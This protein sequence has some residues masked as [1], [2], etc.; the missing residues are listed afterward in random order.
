MRSALYG[1][2]RTVTAAR[3][4]TPGYEASDA[5]PWIGVTGLATMA[6]LVILALG[7]AAV[8]LHVFG[9]QRPLVASVDLPPAGPRLTVWSAPAAPPACRTRRRRSGPAG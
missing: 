5:P 4:K 6:A 7:L 2:T 8:A 3:R 9:H 1:G